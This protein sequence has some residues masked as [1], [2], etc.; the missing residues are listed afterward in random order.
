[1]AGSWLLE[2]VGLPK[3][4]QANFDFPRGK[5]RVAPRRRHCES[6]IARQVHDRLVRGWVVGRAG[7]TVFGGSEG[8]VVDRVE[9]V[10]TFPQGF[11]LSRAA[12]AEPLRNAHVDRL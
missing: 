3:G 1:M 7:G 9:D 4:L 2:L 11:N 8:R 6:R 5:Q 12:D 10:E